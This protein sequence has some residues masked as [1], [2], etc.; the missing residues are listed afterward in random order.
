M[1]AVSEKPMSRA[2]ARGLG[3]RRSMVKSKAHLRLYH[4][5]RTLST[6]TKLAGL[7]LKIVNKDVAFVV[8]GDGLVN[9]NI[10]FATQ[11]ID[12]LLQ[13]ARICEPFSINAKVFKILMN[14]NFF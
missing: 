11:R 14:A 6:N 13:L 7:K 2:D 8:V 5:C 3:N 10:G 9:F 12:I 1:P 4:R